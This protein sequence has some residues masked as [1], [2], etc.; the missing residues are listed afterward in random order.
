MSVLEEKKA[1]EMIGSNPPIKTGKK[2]RP[3]GRKVGPAAP[4]VTVGKERGG[5]SQ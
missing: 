3:I 5:G 2:K 4:I 1:E